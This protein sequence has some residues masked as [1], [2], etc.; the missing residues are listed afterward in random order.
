MLVEDDDVIAATTSA[1]GVPDE[2]TVPASADS[3]SSLRQAIGLS[4]APIAA[5]IVLLLP[6]RSLT[7]PAH[8]LA[9]V[10]AAVVVL[11]IT[12]AI[13]LPLT[14][15]IG[16]TACVLLQVAPAREVFLPF[17]DP[18]IFL[19]IGAFILARAIFLHRLD[20]RLAFAIL[21]MPWV[22]G[23]PLRVLVAFGAVT[24]FISAWIANAA[25][26]AMMYAIAMSIVNYL[27]DSRR[28]GGPL[29]ARSYATG[30]LLM[31]AFA[32]SV[33]GLATPIGAA[34]NLIGLGLIRDVAH[35][36]FSFLDWC[37]IGAPV[38]LVLFAY[39]AISLSF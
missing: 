11:W 33:G 8:R 2:S 39:V 35:I 36:D 26:T 18:L 32:A 28:P 25:T 6:L 9:A 31:A 19:F 29:V 21:S 30:L 24:A 12:E 34:P 10:I 16:A 38:A 13:P 4:L 20:R 5:M 37:A 22:G 27:F 17:A 23:R 3:S 7:V 1:D 14:A 15:L